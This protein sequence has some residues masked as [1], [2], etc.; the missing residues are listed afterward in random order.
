MKKRHV[1]AI[2]LLLGVAVAA[3][4]L[5]AVRMA[6]VADS[7]AAVE[8]VSDAT[9]RAREAKL[10]TWERSLRDAL[11]AKPPRLPPIPD[12]PKAAGGSSPGEAQVVFVDAPPVQGDDEFEHEED[13]ESEHEDDD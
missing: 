5:A 10:D 4:S 6:V 12:V 11:D 1:L 3:G 13:G 8:T 2:S 9:I 7:T